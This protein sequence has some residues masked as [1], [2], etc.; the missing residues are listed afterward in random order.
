MESTGRRLRQLEVF[1]RHMPQH[2]KRS[3]GRGESG[4]G[5][6][7][8]QA[9]G[10]HVY[11]TSSDQIGTYLSQVSDMKKNAKPAKPWPRKAC[12]RS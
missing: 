1:L 7:H 6:T 3:F 9:L 12:H 4:H 2:C 8:E 5:P 10:L 11:V